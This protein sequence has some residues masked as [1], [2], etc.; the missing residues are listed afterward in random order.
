MPDHGAEAARSGRPCGGA[1]PGARRP[2]R[3]CG[4][5][6]SIR[7]ISS[8]SSGA[9]P[10]ASASAWSCS[11]VTRTR[12]AADH[13]CGLVEAGQASARARRRRR[14]SSRSARRCGGS[15]RAARG[16]SLGVGEQ[17]DAAVGVQELVGHVGAPGRRRRPG[18]GRWPGGT[19]RGGGRRRRPARGGPPNGC[20][21][22]APISSPDQALPLE[23]AHPGDHRQARVEVERERVSTLPRSRDVRT[24]PCGQSA[25]VV[26][27]LSGR[28][29]SVTTVTD[30]G[31]SPCA[32]PRR[33][34]PGAAVQPGASIVDRSLAAR[35]RALRL[36]SSVGRAFPW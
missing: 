3:A 16:S 7:S 18:A 13:S 5:C 32:G 10:V 14:R 28:P 20:D 27:E 8:A 17:V 33:G 22:R 35:R 34:R 4:G 6:C 9:D 23:L 11:S 2:P 36:L 30:S 15:A 24:A 21:P 26:A 12:A 31:A 25:D 1:G 19:R 29:L